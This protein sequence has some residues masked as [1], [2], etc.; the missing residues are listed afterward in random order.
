MLSFPISPRSGQ[1]YAAPNGQ[2]YVFDGVKWLGTTISSGGGG[3][4]GTSDYSWLIAADDSTQRE[5]LAGETVKLIGAGTITTTSDAEGNITITG[6]GGSGTTVASTYSWSIAAD[7]STQR[8]ISSSETVKFIGAGGITTSS[9]DEGNITIT[10]SGVVNNIAAYQFSVAADDSTQR[11][12]STDEVIKFVGAGG[13]TTTSDAE[14][15]ITITQGTTS[16]LVNGSYTASLSNAGVLTLPTVLAGDTSIGTEFNTNPP[17]HTLTLKHNGGTGSGSGNEIKFDYGNTKIKVVKDAGT[18]QTWE[19]NSDGTLTLP[20]DLVNPNGFILNAGDRGSLAIGTFIEVPGVE[21]HFHIAFPNS[22]SQEP[23]QD[24]YLGNDFNYFKIRGSHNE[25]TLGVDIGVDGN[26]WEFNPGGSI[27]FPDTT[28]QITA[29]TGVADYNNL[30]NKPNL[31]GTYQ[32]SVAADDSTQRVISTDELIKFIGAGGITTSSDAEGNITITGSGGSVSSLINGANTV[33]LGSDG[34]LTIPGDIKSNGNINIDIN[35]SDS[36]LHRWSFGEDGE[37]TLPGGRT[38]IGTLLGS[39]AIIAN[40]DT[41]FGVVTQ[42]T[43]GSGVLLWIEDSENF[44]TSNLAAV[45]TNPAS[46]G[47]VRIAT[48]ANGGPGPKF[49]DFNDSGALTFPQGTTIATADGTDAFIIDGAVDKDVQIYTYS[50]ATA[51]GWTFGTDGSLT[52]PGDIKSNGNINIDINLT[53]STLRRW[54]FGEDGKLTFPDGANYAGQ[55]VTMPTTTIGNTNSFVW[56]FSDNSIGSDRITLNWNLLASDTA[57]F[58]IGTTHSTTGKY[59]FLDGTDQ[60]LSYFPDG[61]P[62][63]GKLIFGS[64]AGNNAGDA[65][66]IEIKAA[67]GD[68]YLTSTESVKITVDAADSSARIWTFDPTGEL[69][70]PGPISGLGNAK[71]DF[72]T[73]GANVAYLT[74][75]S[76]DTTALIMGTTSAELYAHTDIIIRTNTG[77]TAKVWN[78]NPDGTL[79]FPNATVQSTA[80]TGSL[81]N[82]AYGLPVS[83][84]LDTSANLILPFD[85]Y[86]AFFA[87]RTIFGNNTGGAV[88]SSGQ[89]KANVVTWPDGRIQLVTNGDGFAFAGLSWTFGTDGHLTIP[90]D[91]RSEG[92]IN[93]DIN[94]SDSTLRRWQFGE[95]G[96]LTLP[97]GGDILN[98][99]GT[100]VLGGGGGSSSTLVNGAFE[101]SLGATGNLTIPGDILSENEINIDLNLADSTLRRWTFGQDGELLTPGNINTTATTFTLVNTTATTVNFAG[102]ATTL[103]IANGLTSTTAQ[104]MSIATGTNTG[105]KTINIGT[106][107][108]SA[109]INLGSAVAGA[110]TINSSSIQSGSATVSLF[111]STSTNISFATAATTL[112]IGSTGAGAITTLNAPTVIGSNVTQNLYNTVATT[113]NEFG[114]ATTINV[115][116]NAAAATTWTLGNSA[117]TNTLTVAGGSSSGTDSITSTVTTGIINVFTGLTTGT[118]NIATGSSATAINIGGATSTTTVGNGLTVRGPLVSTATAGITA[119]EFDTEQLTIIGNRIATTVT[120]ANLE[121][122]CNGTGGVVINNIAEATTASTARSVGYLGIPASTVTTT[123]TL[124]IADAGEHVYVTT[125]SQTITIPANSSVA[126]PV[127]TTITFIAGPSATTV[128]I[129]I[130]SDTMYLAGTGTTGTRTLAAHG[131]ATAVKVAATTWYINGTGLT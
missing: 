129:A 76:D 46:L 22:N 118:L 64:S 93:I 97:T 58:Y 105:G 111:T 54:Q 49:W 4:G 85:G 5:I 23:Y 44:G 62:G 20:G 14:G 21:E 9:D 50:G 31:A 13:I 106:G 24:L 112:A 15:N 35:L 80:W 61:V 101:A 63:G 56:E 99:A 1:S 45:Y 26:R 113:V 68:V 114:V 70:V 123:N 41:A 125:N 78:F 43:N 53:D 74:T 108:G 121:L 37:L 19:F 28:I 36:T 120:N 66:A 34:A 10:G 79:T 51:R 3:G 104:S 81:T 42:G 115:A 128:T 57:G 33:S 69:T 88:L 30:T 126:Y 65:N 38:R 87:S 11:L 71:L 119:V 127:G 94:L 82:T 102:A 109:T 92:N 17:G 96:N 16:S 72:T 47:I 103:T 84:S 89:Q 77:G 86:A 95:D 117:N 52:L 100:S 73:Y 55:T 32:F 18:T 90:G 116:S 98:S 27:T 122:E 75:T 131:M 6:T 7:D 48:G 59:L 39:D 110:T 25:Q 2:I 107:G 91:I 12:V 29:W 130:T 60:S 67:S 8:E 40:E 124:T 83:V